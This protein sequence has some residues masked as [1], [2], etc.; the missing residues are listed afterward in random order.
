MGQVGGDPDF[1]QKPI[2]PERR[3]QIGTQDLDRHIP[4]VAEISGQINGGH[5]AHPEPPL[6]PVPIGEGRVKPV[7]L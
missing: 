7:L 2:G 5:A 1:A 3:G 6:D 4:F